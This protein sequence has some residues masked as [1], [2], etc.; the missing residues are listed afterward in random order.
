MLYANYQYGGP[1]GSRSQNRFDLERAYLNFRTRAGERDS[2]RITLDVYQQRDT[3]RDGYYRGW[4]LRA[5]YAYLQHEFLRGGADNLRISARMGLVHTVVIDKEEQYWQRGLSQVAIEQTGFFSSSDAGVASTITLP[6]RAGELY[7]TI[8]NGSGYGSRELDRFKEYA[9]R[10]TLTPF[11]RGSGSL[12]SLQIS[13]WG[14]LGERASDYAQ[15]H[16]TV[17]AVSRGRE[18]NRYGLFVSTRGPRLTLGAQ[19]AWRKDVVEHAD[20]TRDV[21]PTASSR[22]GRVTSLFAIG[23]PFA[24]TPR[25]PGAPLWVVVRLDQ[26]KPD[27]NADGVVHAW[28]AGISWDFSSRTSATLDL[29]SSYPVSGLVAP[30]TRTVYLHL[31]AGF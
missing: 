1:K 17:Q 19:L 2:I 4:S 14:S 20:T 25:S 31:I 18:R 23:H 6:D 16:G 24:S 13:P 27:V 8:V 5:K 28:T 29:Q 22:T 12:R 10:L 7:T 21:V 30:N 26:V 9:A 15:R 11:A 3:T